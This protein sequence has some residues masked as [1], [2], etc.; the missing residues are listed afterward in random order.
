MLIKSL[1]LQNVKSYGADGTPIPFQPGVNMIWGE[2]GSGKS[3]ILEAIGYLLSGSLET[4]YTLQRFRREGAPSGEIVLTFVSDI[5]ERVYQMIRKLGQGEVYLYDP[6]TERR[7]TRTKREAQTWLADHTGVAPEGYARI[8]FSNAVGVPQGQM[9]GIFLESGQPRKG[10]FDPLL[11]VEDYEI[12]WTQLLDTDRYLREKIEQVGRQVAQLQGRLERLERVEGQVQE[13]EARVA[14]DAEALRQAQGRLDELQEELAALDAARDA[15][16]TLTRQ[17]EQAEAEMGVIQAQTAEAQE[18]LEQALEASRVVYKSEAGFSAFRSATIERQ[19]FQARRDFLQERLAELDQEQAEIAEIESQLAEITEGL[20][21]VNQAEAR[22]AELAT[23]MEKQESLRTQARDLESRIA[24][25]QHAPEKLA[26]ET[27]RV[28]ALGETLEK[29]QAQLVRR[30]ELEGQMAEL[31]GQRAELTQQLTASGEQISVLEDQRAEAASALER[32]TCDAQEWENAKAQQAAAQQALAEYRASLD[33]VE[34]QRQEQEQIQAEL[35][36]IARELAASRDRQAAARTEQAQSNQTLQALDERLRLLRETEE[37]TCPICRRFLDAPL[38]HDLEATFQDEQQALRTR[39]EAARQAEAEADRAIEQLQRKRKA[40]QGRLSTLPGPSH[41][42]ALR[43]LIQQ[44]QARV[45][46]WRAQEAAFSE[47]IDGVARRRERLATLEAQLADLR[48]QQAALR[49]EW[50]RVEARRER[51]NVELLRLPQSDRA[52]ELTSSLA[53][54][55]QAQAH[56]QAEGDALAALQDE[57]AEAE[58]ALEA[59]G[60]PQQELAQLQEWTEVRPEWEAAQ[61]RVQGKLSWLVY[62][63]D[64]RATLLQ[65]LDE[66]AVELRE[67]EATLEK[68]AADEQRYVAHDR[69]ARTRSEREETLARL[70]EREAALQARRDALAERHAVAERAYD[71]ARHPQVR[72]QVE[73]L[74]AQVVQLETRLSERRTHLAPAQEE[75]ADLREQQQ[76]LK[77]V[78]SEGHRLERLMA[79]LRFVRDGIRSAGPLVVQRRVRVISY[80]ANRIFNDIMQD[81]SLVLCWDETY[82]ISVRRKDQERGF[83]QLSGGEQMAAALAVRLA[84]LLQ[85]S[86]IRFIF[87]DEPTANLDDKR[88]DQ[89]A[90]RITRLK[91]LRQVFVITHDDAFERETHHV[92]HVIKEQGV[93]RVEVK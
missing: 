34:A 89:L 24:E 76:A 65:E 31:T 47:A 21:R 35:D 39:C 73:T 51:L 60:D 74:K 18:E 87:L 67:L 46:E 17:L 58:T 14:A 19:S 33:D 20:A 85:L 68:H 27:R 42:E 9:T 79:A 53:Q 77:A 6:D 41:A 55:Q 78:M 69:I 43:R 93:S 50:E 52:A 40:L 84:L 88:R 61:D 3:T 66:I 80:R 54:A 91:G 25:R 38:A 37:A 11:R 10:V 36:A 83:R 1:V 70:Q 44:G 63:Q 82:A 29:L 7:L 15:F 72:R 23:L 16:D 22:S 71:A 26:E 12:A 59:L 48:R 90:D 2:N 13:L 75:L 32:A 56:W 45:D 64:S 81:A 57:L 4:G 86:Q 92:L 5:D 30:A 62:R 8:L 49:Q 28:E